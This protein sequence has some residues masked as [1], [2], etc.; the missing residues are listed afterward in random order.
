MCHKAYQDRMVCMKHGCISRKW[1][2]AVQRHTCEVRQLRK[3]M[4]GEYWDEGFGFKK[5]K[6]LDI[7]YKTGQMIKEGQECCE[8]G[9]KEAEEKNKL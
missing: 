9:K 5:G 4:G 7:P 3:R 2:Q 6:L 1:P 8:M